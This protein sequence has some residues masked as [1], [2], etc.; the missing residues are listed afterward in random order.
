MAFGRKGSVVS[1]RSKRVSVMLGVGIVHA[2]SGRI[3]GF[4]NVREQ[5]AFHKW[6]GVRKVAIILEVWR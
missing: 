4:R 3:E 1:D 6:M 5:R 2:M